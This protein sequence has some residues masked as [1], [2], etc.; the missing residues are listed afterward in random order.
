[1]PFI[2][3]GPIKIFIYFCIGGAD[4][5]GRLFEDLHICPTCWLDI[6]REP[7]KTDESRMELLYGWIYQFIQTKRRT[8][9]QF[10]N[11]WLSKKKAFLFRRLNFRMSTKVTA[12]SFL[13]KIIVR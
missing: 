9:W 10:Q 3:G 8:Y 12:M 11:L 6:V 4:K 1:M 5:W 13:S 7:G 2:F